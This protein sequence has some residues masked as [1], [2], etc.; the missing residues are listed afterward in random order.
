MDFLTQQLRAN[1]ISYTEVFFRS[2]EGIT[3]LGD[4]LFVSLI[5]GNRGIGANFQVV[6]FVQ[7]TPAL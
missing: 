2:S 5:L 3:H 7:A 1:N 4:R 6:R